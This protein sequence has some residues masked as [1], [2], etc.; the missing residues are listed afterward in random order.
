MC[1]HPD[2][3]LLPKTS[4]GTGEYPPPVHL[5]KFGGGDRG[6]VATIVPSFELIALS[7]VNSRPTTGVALAHAT[8]NFVGLVLTTSDRWH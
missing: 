4:A 8:M 7:P 1:Q 3:R 5:Q 6:R 2:Q